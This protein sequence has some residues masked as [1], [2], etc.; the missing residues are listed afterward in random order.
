MIDAPVVGSLIIWN[1]IDRREFVNRNRK[2]FKQFMKDAGVSR[3]FSVWDEVGSQNFIKWYINRNVE[4]AFQQAPKETA[5]ENQHT[6]PKFTN[7]SLGK[8]Y[9]VLT[10]EIICDQIV[11]FVPTDKKSL[12]LNSLQILFNYED[13]KWNTID[14]IPTREISVFQNIYDSAKLKLPE[15][16][17]ECFLGAFEVDASRII[18]RITQ[19][20]DEQDVTWTERIILACYGILQEIRTISHKTGRDENISQ[21]IDYS[22]RLNSSM[23]A[24]EAEQNIIDQVG[25]QFQD[26]GSSVVYGLTLEKINIFLCKK[27]SFLHAPDGLVTSLHPMGTF[28]TNRWYMFSDNITHP[29]HIVFP[30]GRNLL[31]VLSLPD[32]RVPLLTARGVTLTSEEGQFANQLL[33]IKV[34]TIYCHPDDADKILPYLYRTDAINY[35]SELPSILVSNVTDPYKINR[36]TK[37][38]NSVPGRW[39][40]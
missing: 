37:L 5:T 40:S 8:Q 11:D 32:W 39:N 38:F 25:L 20:P 7:I 24:T 16:F 33:S 21:F 3:P 22:Q 2:T 26:F 30:L 17:V 35:Y 34:D 15:K 27:W 14:T 6:V 10:Q 31:W 28:D 1:E 29:S 19:N 18:Q 12:N 4:I 9:D 23:T 13:N 36:A